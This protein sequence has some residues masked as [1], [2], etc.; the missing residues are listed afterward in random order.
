[1]DLEDYP[2]ML[3]CYESALLNQH[4]DIPALI[5]MGKMHQELLNLDRAD[6]FFNQAL[7][8]NPD[9]VEAH[10]AIGANHLLRGDFRKGWTEMEWRLRSPKRHL[11]IY[12]FDLAKPKWDGGNFEGKTLLVHAEQGF[13]DTIQFARFLPLVKARGGKVIFQVQ[14]PLVRL[15]SNLAAADVVC[16]MEGPGEAIQDFDFYIPLMSLPGLLNIDIQDLTQE[17]VYL[18]ANRRSAEQ[19]K[20]RLSGKGLH[21]G[22]I[23]SGNPIHPRNTKRNI[24]VDQLS[25]L[26]SLTGFNWYSLQMNPR[27]ASMQVLKNTLGIKN[28]AEVFYDFADTAGAIDALDLVISVDTAVAHLSGAMGKPTWVLL[29]YFPDWRWMMAREDSPWYPG[30]KL[31]RQQAPGDWKSVTSRLFSALMQVKTEVADVF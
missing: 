14:Q 25:S 11:T 27:Q 2:K 17:S 19:W 3:E 4:G 6:H 16:S 1:M 31:V 29:P 20:R 21:I 15:F 13:G 5:N 7:E 10:I 22:L 23:W 28:W 30:M 12:P 8:M 18:H 26:G 9:L 24:P